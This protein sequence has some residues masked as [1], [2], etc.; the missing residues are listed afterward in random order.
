MEKI[1]LKKFGGGTQPQWCAEKGAPEYPE[2][3]QNFE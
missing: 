1:Y 2:Y 3:S